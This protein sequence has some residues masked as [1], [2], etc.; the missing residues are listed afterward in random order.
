[1]KGPA[2]ASIPAVAFRDCVGEF[3]TGVTVV[4]AE[5]DGEAAGMTLN[6]FTSVSLEPLLVLVS[7][8]H[9]SRTLAA[10][11][12]SGSFAASILHRGQRQVAVD[13]AE[14]GAPFPHRHVQRTRDGFLAVTGA[15]AVLC[16][17]VVETIAAGDHDLV[18]GEVVA[19]E[20][21]GG[22]PLLFYRGRFGGMHT[23]AVVPAGHPISLDEG[24]GW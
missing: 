1:M 20:H 19:I 2:S 16:C 8:G 15:S 4:T 12:K 11:V 10:T 24:A 13:F 22:E 3:A 17:R 7:L 5:I 23:D 18:L 9:G 21:G 14:R 6:S